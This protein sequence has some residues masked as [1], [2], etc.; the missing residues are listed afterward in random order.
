MALATLPGVPAVLQDPARAL[1][2]QSVWG[3]LNDVNYQSQRKLASLR[4]TQWSVAAGLI[5]QRPWLGWGSAAFS[6]I[7]PLRTGRWHGHPHNIAFD[8]AVSFGLPVAALVVG[9]VLWLLI[10]SLRQGMA[11]GPV[12]DRAWWASALVVAVL[13]ASDI[14]MYDSRLNIAGWILLAG[15]RCWAF[16]PAPPA[17]A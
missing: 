17:G 10:R 15:L 2:P 5:A 11:A 14:P 4:I 1:V 7:Y 6:V 8:L 3:R 16:R 9:F 12:F 13:H